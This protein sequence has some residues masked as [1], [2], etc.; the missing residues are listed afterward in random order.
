MAIIA[1]FQI[2]T[3]PNQPQ[4]IGI[5]IVNR[6]QVSTYQTGQQVLTGNIT[7]GIVITNRGQV[8]TYQTGQQVL[9]INLLFRAPDAGSGIAY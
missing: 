3:A 1:G 5:V 6:G 8:S 4:A 2:A 7:S 9:T